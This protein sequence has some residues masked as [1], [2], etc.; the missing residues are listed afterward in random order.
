M[1]AELYY[2]YA[3][4][5]GLCTDALPSTLDEMWDPD[6]MRSTPHPI[7]DGSVSTQKPKKY[8]YK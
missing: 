8:A 6:Q 1:G 7:V 3:Y 2:L 5:F 4:F